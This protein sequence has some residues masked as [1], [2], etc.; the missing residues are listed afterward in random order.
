MRQ[1]K[2]TSARLLRRRPTRP[3]SEPEPPRLARFHQ[4]ASSSSAFINVTLVESRLPDFRQ[5][6][7]FTPACAPVSGLLLVLPPET[8]ARKFCRYFAVDVSDQTRVPVAWRARGRGSP[9][10]FTHAGA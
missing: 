2:E 1:G 5:Q 9:F 6:S 4:T 10:R 8:R 3:A 7:S